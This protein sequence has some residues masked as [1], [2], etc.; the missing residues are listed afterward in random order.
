MKV[1]AAALAALALALAGAGASRTP[2]TKI[3]LAKTSAFEDAP[4]PR[5]KE[6]DSAP[7]ERAARPRAFR[8]APPVIPHGTTDFLPITRD[9]NSC[10]DC[11]AV[12]GKKRGE[13][14]PIPPS[15]YLDARSAPPKKTETV[16]G[17][18]WVCTSCHVLRQDVQ[19][20]VR[21]P[22]PR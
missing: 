20:L 22:F 17:A 4:P 8:G 19:P 12:A 7:G 5:V 6:N 14:T 16:A 11:H 2:D 1:A 21:N 10:V 3:G 13:P 9:R 15:H 18:R